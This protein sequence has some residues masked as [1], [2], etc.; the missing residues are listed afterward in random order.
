MSKIAG[1][2]NAEMM[3]TTGATQSLTD[4]MIQEI[5]SLREQLAAALAA[6]K[7]KDEAMQ[8]AKY[9]VEA[10][11]GTSVEAEQI[12]DRYMAALLIQPDDSALMAWL[13]EPVAWLHENRQDSDVITHAVK[14]VWNGVVVG[15]M[16]QY[17]IP[18]YSPKGLK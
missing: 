6:C 13:G 14:N 16:A 3:K 15:K 1:E 4:R 8:D 7:L 12:H 5:E 10:I 11:D 18:L 2:I 9:A 17:S